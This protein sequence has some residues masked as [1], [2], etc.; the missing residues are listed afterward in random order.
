MTEEQYQALLKADRSHSLGPLVQGLARELDDELGKILGA[1]ELA[2]ARD[3][4]DEPLA[5][6][7]AAVLASRDVAR[8]LLAIG[9]EGTPDAGTAIPVRELIEE[10]VRVA[11]AG[12]NAEIAMAVADGTRPVW[13]ERPPLLQALLALIRNAIEAAPPPPGRAKVQVN[14]ANTAIS[15]GQVAGL[16][17]GDYVEL[18]VRD[19]GVGIAPEYLERI[20]DPLFSTRKH[21]AG[22][23]LPTALAAV[24]RHGGQI[25]VDSEPGVGT[26][27]TV[28]LPHAQPLEYGG[29][30]SGTG[31][32]FRTGR[33]LVMDDDER[34]RSVAERLLEKL[35]YKCDLA[36]DGDEAVA[37][38]RRYWNVGR[39][40]DAVLV[41]A[42]TPGTMPAAEMI[43][44]LREF[45]PDARA[46][47]CGPGAADDLKRESAELGCAGW[48]VKP[49]RLAELG[50]V[51]QTV[52][53]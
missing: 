51:L 50:A 14:A 28:F 20:W 7:E 45:D 23:G 27:F 21:G 17:A 37:Q 52:I 34:M 31:T 2:R 41:D 26:V 22:L 49:Y 40:H 19:N 3:P 6:A 12:A 44:R 15:A 5:A 53:A 38:Y 32:R 33:I 4:R 39:P 48:L 29:G 18:E 47:L 36:R 9:R 25:G 16:P 42:R 8:R 13:G 30:R 1:V 46:I 11:G 35:D 24:R 10:A 43:L